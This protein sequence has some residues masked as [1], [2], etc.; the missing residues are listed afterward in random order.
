M[1]ERSATGSSFVEARAGNH[2]HTSSK[3]REDT[4]SA[5]T[6]QLTT[7]PFQALRANPVAKSSSSYDQVYHRLRKGILTRQI[8]PGARLVETELARELGVSRTPVREAL[9]RLESDGFVERGGSG[10]LFARPV[11]LHE[12]DDI[13]LIRQA[14]DRV[15]AGLAAERGK[16]DD[17]TDLRQAIED[18]AEAIARHGP[19]SPEFHE[20][21][22]LFHRVIYDIAFSPRLAKGIAN[23][24]LVQLEVA[25]ELS[26]A[27]PTVTLPA[28]RQHDHLLEALESGDPARAVAA[29]DAHTARSEEDAKRSNPWT[30]ATSSD[31][32]DLAASRDVDTADGRSSR[33]RPH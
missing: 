6:T 17:W 20:V 29:V 15:A 12:I 30:V 33:R 24:I 22:F 14:L 4:R 2:E 32:A 28:T 8:A 27:D 11:D 26:Y 1:S 16:P 3:N 9:R 5:R 7:D 18:M 23:H 13:F 25:A 21:H 19:S 10:G 31:S